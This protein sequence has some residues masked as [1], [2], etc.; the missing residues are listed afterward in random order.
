MQQSRKMRQIMCR[1]RDDHQRLRYKQTVGDLSYQTYEHI[2]D[3][4][5][6]TNVCTVSMS[7]RRPDF[8]RTS[9]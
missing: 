5:E 6:N 1:R 7:S 8:F 3:I 9:R 2:R 4:G